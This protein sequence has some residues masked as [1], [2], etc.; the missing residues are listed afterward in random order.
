MSKEFVRHCQQVTP[1]YTEQR[2]QQTYCQLNPVPYYAQ[3]F[4]HK[5]HLDQNEKL[6]AYGVTHV[7]ASDGCNGKILGIVTMPV[8]NN[9]CI[10]GDLYR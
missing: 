7:A 9:L 6:V 8:K 2:Q 5:M 1:L 10:Y 4:G 3:Y